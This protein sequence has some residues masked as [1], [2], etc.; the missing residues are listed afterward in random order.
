MTDTSGQDER[1][2]QMRELAAQRAQEELEQEDQRRREV[3]HQQRLEEQRQVEEQ[4]REAE[5]QEHLAEQVERRAR[6]ELIAEDTVNAYG[7]AL[8]VLRNA[9]YWRQLTETLGLVSHF[10]DSRSNDNG[11]VTTVHKRIHPSVATVRVLADGLH[12]SL[13]NPPGIREQRWTDARQQ[14][15]ASLNLKDLEM[16][17]DGVAVNLL[18]PVYRQDN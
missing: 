11:T 2:E 7:T 3:Q 8:Q 16:S 4:R 18:A 1:M 12:I 6:R 14:L 17:F 5:R 9:P 15:A 13:Q 10:T